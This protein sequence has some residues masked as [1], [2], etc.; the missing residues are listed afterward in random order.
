MKN[1]DILFAFPLP[2]KSSPQKT[3]ALSIFYPGEAAAKEGFTVDYWDERFDNM[4]DFEEKAKRANIIGLSSLS[5]FQLSRTIEILKWCKKNFPQ[6]PTILGGVHATFLPEN[7]LREPF[8]DYVI[9]GEGEER[10]PKL[11][12]AIYSEE[13]LSSIDGVGYKK[14]GCI[15][16][17]PRTSVVN[18]QKNYVCPI[19]ERTKRYFKIAAKRNEVIIQTSRGCPWSKRT[20]S[21][22]SVGRQYLNTY[23]GI[24]FE[25]WKEDMEKIYNLYPFNFIEL[26]DENSLYFVQNIDKFGSYLKDKNIKYQLFLRANQLLDENVI[27]KLSETGCIRI[28]IGVE[29]G[30]ERV[31]NQI[32]CKKER[33]EDFYLAAKLLSKYGI[34]AVYTYIIGNPTETLEEMMETLA[35]SDKISRLHGRKK[36]RSTIYILMILPGTSIFEQAKKANWKIPKDMEEWSRV[37]AAYNPE[38]PLEINNIYYI[39]GIHHNHY[40]KT[41]QN[42]SGLWRLIILPFEILCEIRWYLRFFKYF[43]VEH[44]LIEKLLSWRSKKSKGLKIY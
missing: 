21:F 6:K 16:I 37:S 32:L 7:S 29:S 27:K 17:Q 44:F 19:S 9:I 18:F 23:R 10:I 8:V 1:I 30:N 43:K 28:H 36:S 24:P 14:D 38:L 20:C 41:S 12:N 13:G 25:S 34:K 31:R 39:G 15:I 33:L 11:L 35:V 22:C 40:Y 4:K 26:E 42:F 3:P 2:S 5:G